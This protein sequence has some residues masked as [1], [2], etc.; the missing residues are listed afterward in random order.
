LDFKRKLLIIKGVIC[1]VF[2]LNELALAGGLA[3][4]FNP[5][6][7]YSG[8][9]INSCAKPMLFWGKGLGGLGA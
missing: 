8:W 3:C 4:C 1:K 7:Q 6:I 2:F 9:S 5:Y